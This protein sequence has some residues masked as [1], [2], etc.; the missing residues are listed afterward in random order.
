MQTINVRLAQD[1]AAEMKFE[2]VDVFKKRE[3]VL[4]DKTR[5][6]Y[7][8]ESQSCFIEH[9]IDREIGVSKKRDYRIVQYVLCR[10]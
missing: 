4:R 6:C 1:Y 8:A 7:I 2:R 10:K 5:L 3:R 9:G